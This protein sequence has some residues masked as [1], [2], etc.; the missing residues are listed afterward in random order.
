MKV[1]MFVALI[2]V[3][4]GSFT[5]Q[6]SIMARALFHG[7]VEFVTTLAL[8]AAYNI[9]W[10]LDNL[11]VE[12][13]S[14]RIAPQL[15]EFDV[16]LDDF[17]ATHPFAA[18]PEFSNLQRVSATAV[19]FR[20]M[21]TENPEILLL[22]SA[23]WRLLGKGS[24]KWEMT[25]GAVDRWPRETLLRAAERE[26]WEEAGIKLASIEAVVHY[27]PFFCWWMLWAGYNMKIMFL[28][29]VAGGD[30]GLQDIRLNPA[31]HQAFCWAT[32][33]QLE[34]MTAHQSV[35]AGPLELHGFEAK[36][37]PDQWA[38]MQYISE[39]GRTGALRAFAE[40]DN[41]K[42]RR[43]HSAFLD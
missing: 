28:A 16:P 6:S 27:H 11:S 14:C 41:L 21:D 17:L 32:R 20:K 25:G 31:E 22:Q 29:T 39:S 30:S 7:V 12:K 10:R 36:P 34:Q 43:M 38:H 5:I 35:G 4:M 18:L 33:A 40:L 37:S 23:R 42:R 2:A 1:A 13:A 9:G 8:A 24:A 3:V 19:I 26:A 15:M